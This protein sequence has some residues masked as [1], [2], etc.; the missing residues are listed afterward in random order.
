[1][2]SDRG[3]V[4]INGGVPRNPLI[5][6]GLSAINPEEEFVGFIPDDVSLWK[7]VL[8]DLFHFNAS[9][10]PFYGVIGFPE[11]AAIAATLI[12][13]DGRRTSSLLRV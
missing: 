9:Q 7:G 2:G 12:I 5:V 10:D 3:F 13:E 6:N 11:G 1:M 8:E 4:F